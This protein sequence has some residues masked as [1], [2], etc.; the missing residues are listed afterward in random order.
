MS[1]VT[2]A[3]TVGGQVIPVTATVILPASLEPLPPGIALSSGGAL[4][5]E[6]AQAGT[7]EP[8][9]VVTDSDG[10]TA[11]SRITITIAE[12]PVPMP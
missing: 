9:F 4:S 7:W 2:G 1:A 6:S 12:A 3:V 10:N 11:S 5:G 8:E